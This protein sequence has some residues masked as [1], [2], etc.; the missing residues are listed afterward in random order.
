[1]KIYYYLLPSQ[2]PQKTPAQKCLDLTNFT[3]NYTIDRENPLDSDLG[4]AKNVIL[5]TAI[6]FG[7]R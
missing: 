5:V 1:M 3:T 4:M 2:F 7:S 6:A